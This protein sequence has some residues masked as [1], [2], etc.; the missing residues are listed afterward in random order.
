MT[1]VSNFTDVDDK[2]IKASREQND[3][4]LNIAERFIDAFREDVS[5]LNIHRSDY[6]PAGN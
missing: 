2:L 4:V 1:Y 3:T 6:S 5:A